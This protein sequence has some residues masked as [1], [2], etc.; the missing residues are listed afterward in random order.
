MSA[1]LDFR[2][3]SFLENQFTPRSL[4]KAAVEVMVARNA[5]AARELRG[6][7][8]AAVFDGMSDV[9]VGWGEWGERGWRCRWGGST[10]G[11]NGVG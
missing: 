10:G 9:Q 3:Y 1:V 11:V 4:G 7:G 8:K 6:R 5:T 2:E